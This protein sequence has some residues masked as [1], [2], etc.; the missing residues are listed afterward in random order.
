MFCTHLSHSIE[1]KSM[2]TFIFHLLQAQP[3]VR[4][5]Q[6]RNFF[7]VKATYCIAGYL[8]AMAQVQQIELILLYGLINQRNENPMECFYVNEPIDCTL[9]SDPPHSP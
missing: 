5:T 8:Q 1:N 3:K 9:A 6:H 7:V 2:H 4:A